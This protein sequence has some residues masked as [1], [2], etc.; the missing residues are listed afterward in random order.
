MH[1]Y[2]IQYPSTCP[3]YGVSQKS[4]VA[5]DNLVKSK[6]NC[7]KDGEKDLKQ[8]NK[9]LQPRWCPLRLISNPKE[10]AAKDAQEGVH[11]T[12]SGGCTCK[13]DDHKAGMEAQT[14][15]F[16]ISLKKKQD[17]A[18]SIYHP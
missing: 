10:E 8:N 12:T 18:D 13:V 16:I 11:G 3:S 9:Y 4:I 1:P 5:T 2:F 6:L 17:M 14:S 15:C 7:S